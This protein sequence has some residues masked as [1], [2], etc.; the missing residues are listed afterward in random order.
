MKVQDEVQS[1]KIVKQRRYEIWLKRDIN[2]IDGKKYGWNI[3][4]SDHIK[5][6]IDDKTSDKLQS[7]K[8]SNR[9]RSMV[10]SKWWNTI[11]STRIKIVW[12]RNEI[13]SQVK[14]E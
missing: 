7:Q 1:K 14:I 3:I 4:R 13:Q 9:G 11:R 12:S 10:E 5:K 6:K 2:K 8:Y